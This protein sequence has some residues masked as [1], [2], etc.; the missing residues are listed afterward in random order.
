[1]KSPFWDGFVSRPAP[2]RLLE[3]KVVGTAVEL[4]ALEVSREK[5]RQF[6]RRPNHALQWGGLGSGNQAQKSS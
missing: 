3:P 6:N 5:G 2:P 4:P 1:M